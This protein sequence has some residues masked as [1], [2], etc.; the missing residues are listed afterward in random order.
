VELRVVLVTLV[1]LIP[2]AVAAVLVVVAGMQP[3][4]AAA[5]AVPGSLIQ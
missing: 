4:V 3:R 2:A 5:Q 1:A